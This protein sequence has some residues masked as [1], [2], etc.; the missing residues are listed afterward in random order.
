L[1][2]V[3]TLLDAF[4][5]VTALEWC[6]AGL[7]LGYLLLAIRQ[8]AWCWSFAIASAL[9]Y[10]VVFAR[11]G[12]V[13]QSA[14]QL[15]YAGMA[16]YGWRQWRGSTTQ[17]PVAISRWSPR[18]H[19]LAVAAVAVVAAGNGFL[20]ARG[21]AATLLPYADAAIAWGSVLTT[22]MV[23][24]KVLENWLYWIVLDLAMAVLAAWQGLAATSLLF[25]VYA[26]LAVQGYR[27]WSRDL[28][29]AGTDAR[30]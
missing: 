3:A 6:A 20:V 7:A 18:R 9:L 4:A 26:L 22:W 16:L 8:S 25:L 12:L 28:R 1:S 15:F 27:Q 2:T 11:A 19:L 30:A 5:A 10:L 17:A 24:R 23:A 29:A 21:T 14:L 13:M